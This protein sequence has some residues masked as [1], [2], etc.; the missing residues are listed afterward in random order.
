M[1]LTRKIKYGLKGPTFKQFKLSTN[2]VLLVFDNYQV[3]RSGFLHIE[4]SH[5]LLAL[6]N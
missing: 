2:A 3:S 4:I 6:T 1:K 5:E